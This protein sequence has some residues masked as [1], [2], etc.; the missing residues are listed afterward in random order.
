MSGLHRACLSCVLILSIIYLSDIN[1]S[2][3]PSVATESQTIDPATRQA[4]SLSSQS[5]A[6]KT[7]VSDNIARGTLNLKEENFEEAL[8]DFKLAREQDPKSSM[9]A[10]FLGITYKK[11]MEFENARVNLTDA[12]TLNPA[13]AEAVIELADVYYQLG[14]DD[15]ALKNALLSEARGTQ[16]ANTA[17]IKGMILLR[18]G[19]NREAID[20]F[21]K[22]KSID[23]KLTINADY[24]IG[25]A[26]LKEG[27]L[28]EAKDVFNE[29]VLRDPNADIAQFAMQ[30]MDSIAAKQKSERELK[31][32]ADIQYQYDDNV[33]LKPGDS[34]VAANISNE[35]DS[36]TVTMLR[37]E[38]APKLSGRAV[39][40]TQY[41]FYSIAHWKL[42]SHDVMSHNVSLAPGYN[43][44]SGSFSA[45]MNYNYTMVD[46]FKYLQTYSLTPTYQFLSGRGQF[47]NVFVKMQ[48]KEYIKPALSHDEDR[49]SDEWGAGASWYYLLAQNKGFFNLSYAF[50]HEDTHGTNTQYM[51]HKFDVGL[52]YPIASVININLAGEAYHQDFEETNKA[53]SIVRHDKTY[54]ISST[55]S[56]AVTA[57]V[58]ARIQYIYTRG[59]S[60]IAVYDYTKNVYSAGLSA[61]F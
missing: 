38:Y 14:N 54:T 57:D 27:R 48:K 23:A 5:I 2:A 10:Y 19:K 12:V 32:N 11:M 55:L 45:I 4:S 21:K 18:K 7:A 34:Y 37:A 40:K 3:E 58:E 53:F 56:Y 46:D 47:A 22:A 26:N 49:D 15:M 36:A 39:L 28:D 25:L 33:I 44:D 17:F 50:N 16:P 61:S 42:A 9:A 41:S 59:D 13:V 60:N 31:F 24:Q 8:V 6:T 20:S 52:L 29:I 43:M 35:A 51:G 1:A 30:Y